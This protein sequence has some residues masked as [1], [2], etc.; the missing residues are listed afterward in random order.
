[1]GCLGNGLEIGDIV[2]RVANALNV[3][4]L[5]LVVDLGNQVLDLVSN[6]KLCVDSK[7]G[8]ENLQ[9]VVCAAV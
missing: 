1:M 5:G 2:A 6:N 8:Q 7:A 9:L 3:H 4:S